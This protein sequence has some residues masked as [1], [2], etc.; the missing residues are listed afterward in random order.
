MSEDK[1]LSDVVALVTGASRGAGKGIALALGAEGATVYVT[2]RSRQEGD[3]PLPGTIYATA[4]AID[5]AG[6][7]GIPITCDHGDD[8]QVA[9]VFRRVSDAHGR[10]DILVNNATFLHDE[11]TRPG[12]FWEKPLDL[13]DIL[14]VGLRSAYVASWHAAP[15]MTPAHRGLIAFTSSFG[16][17]CY[18]HGPSYGAQ[19]V[20]VD[21]FA[22][23]MAVDLRPYE[24]A[25]VSIW[26]GMLKT[27]RTER[28]MAREPEKYAGFWEL[29]ETPEFTGR[30][31]S[32]IYRDPARMDRSGQVL[33][34]AELAAEYGIA[35]QDGAQPPSHREMLGGPVQAHPAVVE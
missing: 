10:L 16:A 20:G 23:D 28:V 27:E 33:I 1:P 17:R 2:G 12:P 34:G 15:L 26:M 3:A 19:K 35:D 4:E 11:L 7:H 6:G 18:M 8:E 5:A 24:V 13:I 30:L 31:I 14:G 22:Q 21:K 25:A 9:A 32:A 29:A